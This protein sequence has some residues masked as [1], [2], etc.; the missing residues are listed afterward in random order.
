MQISAYTKITAKGSKQKK[1]MV[2]TFI[3][4]A[5]NAIINQALFYIV[6]ISL[7]FMRDGIDKLAY[8]SK[9]SPI[10]IN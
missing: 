7:N 2:C 5:E 1:S 6:E 3:W 10:E 8:I 9:I 4:S